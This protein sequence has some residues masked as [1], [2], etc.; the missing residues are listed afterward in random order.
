[1]PQASCQHRRFN[2]DQKH[3]DLK[4]VNFAYKTHLKIKIVDSQLHLHER[5]LVKN[6]TRMQK[7]INNNDIKSAKVLLFVSPGAQREQK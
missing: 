6:T 4:H 3:Q 7:R 5:L 1:M 2:D